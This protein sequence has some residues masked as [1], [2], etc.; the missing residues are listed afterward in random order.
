[1]AITILLVDDHVM[2]RSG[3]KALLEQEQKVLTCNSLTPL[4]SCEIPTKLAF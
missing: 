2:F 4:S 3:M 1:M